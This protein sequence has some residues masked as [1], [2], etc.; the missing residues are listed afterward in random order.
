[1]EFNRT[2]Q[3]KTPEQLR[4]DRI[5]NGYCDTCRVDP[6]RCFQIKKRFGG[7]LRE[8]I[9]ITTEH[10]V[11]KGICLKCHPDQDPDPG[12]G[13][14][15]RRKHVRNLTHPA[16]GNA[17]RALPS[18]LEHPKAVSSIAHGDGDRRKTMERQHAHRELS[19]TLLSI[20][21]DN[22]VQVKE[23]SSRQ[24]VADRNS[25]NYD[26]DKNIFGDTIDPKYSKSR[27]ESESHHHRHHNSNYERQRSLPNYHITHPRSPQRHSHRYGLVDVD[28][29]HHPPQQGHPSYNH[30]QPPP[31]SS[32]QIPY[33][34]PFSN[35]DEQ[36]DVA[37]R[38]NNYDHDE[39]DESDDQ[40]FMV[41][42]DQPM[43][44]LAK[45]IA[46][47]AAKSPEIN[48][49]FVLPKAGVNLIP[50]AMLNV[51]VMDDDEISLVTLETCLRSDDCT[52]VSTSV[53]RFKGGGLSVVSEETKGSLSTNDHRTVASHQIHEP[54]PPQEN[55]NYL[56]SNAINIQTLRDLVVEFTQADADEV[57]IDVVT[58]AVIQD[59]STNKS[60]DLALFFLTTLWVL[61]RKSDTNKHS[62]IFE[63]ATFDAL[64]EVMRIY[65]TSVEIQTRAC[66]VLWSLSMD[67]NDRKHVAQL[68]GCDGI[69]NAMQAH[70]RNETLH[71]M[72]LGALKVLSLD[73]IGKSTLRLSSASS[74]VADSMGLINNPTIQSEGC[75]IL[76]NLSIEDNQFVRP[77]S[78]KESNAVINA[79]LNN[80]DSLDVHDGACYALLS[81]A[82]SAA[83]VEIIR[84]NARTRM[85]L[86]LAFRK[87]PDAVGKDVQT[88]LER[89]HLDPRS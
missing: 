20:T 36:Q 51:P 14:R 84:R 15:N 59:N 6:L 30:G 21:D 75:A 52:V 83:N 13:E 57:A 38:K 48:R 62:I 72:A 81:F 40:E 60:A 33:L 85:A 78:E 2:G 18:T 66:G 76:C 87:H 5:R 86:E 56:E 61:A 1:M 17:R 3:V 32:A 8:R 25:D 39:S 67:P 42:N 22:A 63:G 35:Q 50:N 58:Q 4:A 24:P 47:Y 44:E 26:A 19:A 23:R 89:L 82:S 45:M 54:S 27:R 53:R 88:L 64:L 68:G 12:H 71:V 9:P 10:K 69:L 41:S 11:Y 37:K 7:V 16:Q 74:I 55:E 77:V 28:D 34:P 31:A 43:D 46:E 65:E 80:P 70:Q 79:I 49:T 73:T 29:H